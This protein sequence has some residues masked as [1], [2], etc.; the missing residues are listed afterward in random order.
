MTREMITLH[1]DPKHAHNLLSKGACQLSAAHLMGHKGE[2]LEVEVHKTVANRLRRAVKNGKSARIY[3]HEVIPIEGG[4]KFLDFFKNLG[5]KIKQGYEYIKPY[6]APLVKE[7]ATKVADVGIAA[8]S[9]YL[10]S[11]V[12]Q[13]IQENKGKAVDALGNVTGAYG[14]HACSACGGNGVVLPTFSG[15]GSGVVLP[16]FGGAMHMGVNRGLAVHRPQPWSNW[17]TMAMP[18]SPAMT[19]K[20]AY[21][22]W[23]FQSD[24][25]GLGA[26]GFRVI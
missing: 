14:M 12:N 18:L 1:F 2:P 16:T 22:G 13:L 7:A 20:V 19:S 5:Q 4:G 21:P 17:S 8:A 23:G 25:Q 15:A 24:Y 9:P 11:S 26:N 10:P 3:S 6:V